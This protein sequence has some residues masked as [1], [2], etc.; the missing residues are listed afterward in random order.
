MINNAKTVQK[1]LAI[2]QSMS[3]MEHIVQ[4]V[5]DMEDVVGPSNP[6]VNDEVHD[7]NDDGI[8]IEISSAPI[9]GLDE[10]NL[11]DIQQP[12]TSNDFIMVVDYE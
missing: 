12:P 9:F 7:S 11:D 5:Q 3:T 10:E 8:A 2:Q 1:I 6:P 4:Q